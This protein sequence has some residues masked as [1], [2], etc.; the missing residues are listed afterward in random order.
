M[1]SCDLVSWVGVRPIFPPSVHPLLRLLTLPL[2]GSSLSSLGQIFWN[3]VYINIALIYGLRLVQARPK[4]TPPTCVGG[5]E[6]SFS[7]VSA[8]H[9]Y[10]QNEAIDEFFTRHKIMGRAILLRWLGTNIFK[11]LYWMMFVSLSLTSLWRCVAFGERNHQQAWFPGLSY[12][13][14]CGLL[15]GHL[16]ASWLQDSCQVQQHQPQ[17]RWQGICR[18]E[19]RYLKWIIMGHY[20]VEVKF[21]LFGEHEKL[22][23]NFI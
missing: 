17:M 23:K 12:E 8:Y 21:S 20:R 2:F 19:F 22:H 14:H 18:R 6:T 5:R 11:W 13:P 7:R 3:S 9:I 4:P 15:L 1:L 16:G 10:I